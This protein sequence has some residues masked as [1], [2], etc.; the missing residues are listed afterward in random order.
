MTDSPSLSYLLAHPSALGIGA[1]HPFAL[2]LLPLIGVF[3]LWPHPARDRIASCLRASAFACVILVLAD[4]HLVTHIPDDQLSVVVGV[5]LSDSIDDE[6]RTWSHTYV[7]EIASRLAPGDELAVLGFAG[8]VELMR[9]PGPPARIDRWPTVHPSSATDLRAAIEN[10]MALFTSTGQRRILLV[11]DGRETR[12]NS[13]SLIPWLRT[14]GVRIDAAIP[15]QRTEPDV[16]VDKIIAPVLAATDRAVPVRVVGVN[17]GRLRAG[18]LNL[19]LDDA[20]V[21]SIAVE[22]P[23]GRTSFQLAPQLSPPGSHSLR[24][25][26]VVDG[27]PIP[28]NNTAE[29]GISIRGRSRLLVLTPHRS[30]RLADVLE[31]R[32]FAVSVQA[33]RSLRSPDA[34]RAYHGVVLED[35]TAADC[36]PTML[37]WMRRYVADFG[38]GLVVAGGAATFGDAAFGQTA[39]RQLLPLTLEPHRPDSSSREPLALFFV[40]DRSNSMGYNS[41]IGT[42]RDGEK[43]R[44]AKQAALAVIRQLRDQDLVGVIAFDSQPYEIAPLSPLGTIRQEL[45]ALIPRIVENGGTDFFDALV[46][47]REQLA[48]SRVTRRHIILL[49]DGDTN[50]AAPVEYRTL[51]Q[52][53]RDEKISVTTI[54][55]GDNTVNLKLL[56]DISSQ[57]G[58]EFH[59]VEDAETLP[60]LMLRETH[61]ALAPR[62]ESTEEYYPHVARRSQALQGIDEDQLP[63]LA[64]YAYARAKP[65]A[66]VLLQVRRL[67]RQDPLLAVWHYG[68]GRVAAFTASLGDDA[69]TWWTWPEH[70]KFWSQVMR[71][72]AR[73]HTEDDLAVHARRR[74]G[75]T[76]IT[77]QGFGPSSDTAVLTA[78]LQLGDV[79]RDVD[80]APR[81]PRQFR[82]TLLDVPAGQYPIT[83]IKRT[84]DGVVSEYTDEVA[85]PDHDDSAD[86][87]L[88]ETTPNVALLTQLCEATG[89]TLNPSPRMLTNR[90][91]GT[92]FVPFALGW[93]LFPLAMALFL[94]DTA[95]RKLGQAGLFGW[96]IARSA[97]LS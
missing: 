68:L 39:L 97:P 19:Y 17:G 79:V 70:G 69:A 27:D 9:E 14:A 78:R 47:A 28:A 89:G 76:E 46:Q 37:E 13:R 55:I 41:R 32:G 83:I 7:N 45:E 38:G 86:A 5:D 71:W 49:T 31:R 2:L 61:R 52:E 66:E 80:L 51:T 25:H 26:L 95:V 65:A 29:V 50:R 92:R 72:V 6:G 44:Y 77:V 20:L 53:L 90:S 24:A 59:Y 64:G 54:R 48:S 11:T 43:L 22:I 67:E 91:P 23:P 12:G 42:L 33:P 96:R 93:L 85:V 35:L 40:I 36:A 30:S 94:A 58:G 18:V 3:F 88:T 16:R 8:T 1:T 63:I 15:P 21:D 75:A 60:D 84:A 62:G 56:R 81:E 34:L 73:E 87:E 74:D 4:V 57:T 10:A 82:T